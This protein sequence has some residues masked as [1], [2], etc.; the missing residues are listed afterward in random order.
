MIGQQSMA[1]SFVKI[2]A[3][4]SLYGRV[5]FICDAQFFRALH[6]STVAQGAMS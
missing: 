2:S 4:H 6:S 3:S 1:H 5:R